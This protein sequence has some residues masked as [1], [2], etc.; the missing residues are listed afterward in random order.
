MTNDE[1]KS[2]EVEQSEIE[3]SPRSSVIESRS[4]KQIGGR[5]R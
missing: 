1:Y 2:F 3:L 4:V 5:V